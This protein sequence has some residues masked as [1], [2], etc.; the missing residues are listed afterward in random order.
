MTSNSNF[1][2]IRT[3]SPQ[4]DDISESIKESLYSAD[5]S[6]NRLVAIYQLTLGL[7]YRDLLQSIKPLSETHQTS[8]L[9]VIIRTMSEL[10]IRSSWIGMNNDRAIWV[11]LGERVDERNRLEEQKNLF[12]TQISQSLAN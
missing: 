1:P 11:L 10:F 2:N 3:I 9:W 12:Y 8:A 5:T 4:L 7:Q 6:D